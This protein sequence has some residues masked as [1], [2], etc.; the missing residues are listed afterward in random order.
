MSKLALGGIAVLGLSTAI[1]LW[2]LLSAREAL[3]A[4]RQAL[5]QAALANQ[6]NQS[7]IT[8]LT[9]GLNTCVAERAATKR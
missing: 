2:Q 7:A 8:T 6:Q 4:S 3:G 5:D 9:D 1:L